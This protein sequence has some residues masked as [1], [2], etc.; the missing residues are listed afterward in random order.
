MNW[1]KQVV[2]IS[3]TDIIIV[4]KDLITPFLMSLYV[5]AND[6]VFPEVLKPILLTP[7]FKK[8]DPYEIADYRP[9]SL[10]LILYKIFGK[11][12]IE[13]KI[14]RSVIYKKIISFQ[15]FNVDLENGYA[16]TVF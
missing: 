6:G 16:P 15:Y 14:N 5:A 1:Q 11:L 10:L 8:W 7:I 2:A 13:G 4:I 3:T 12:V 9:V